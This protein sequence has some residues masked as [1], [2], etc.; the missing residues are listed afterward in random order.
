MRR[1][2]QLAA[3][4]FAALVAGTANAADFALSS[5]D[6][7][8][9]RTIPTPF[10][11][12]ASGCQGRNESPALTW[13]GAPAGTKSFAVTVF[14]PDAPTGHGW[15]HWA[16]ANL[17]ASATHL[18]RGSG[19]AGGD[20]LPG[21]AVQLRN[22]FGAAAYG[23]PCPP[24]GDDAHRYRFRV[25]AVD[26]ES[27]DVDAGDGA[28]SLSSALQGHTLGVAELVATYAR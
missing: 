11:Y 5:S 13:K 8:N 22:D 28:A 12:D 27:L 4:A 3:A 17:P 1:S 16:V 7:S 21:S 24:P 18:S 25:Y 19:A 23:G 9:G 6:I 2:I 20:G 10:V 26:V 15:W 14:D